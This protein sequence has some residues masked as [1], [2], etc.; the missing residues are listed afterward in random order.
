MGHRAF[1]FG[2]S[3]MNLEVFDQTD[4]VARAAADA[5]N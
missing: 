4:L 3:L 1:R 5:E 2:E